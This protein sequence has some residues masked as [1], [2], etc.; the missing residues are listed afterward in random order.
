[1]LAPKKKGARSSFSKIVDGAQGLGIGVA[2]AA[3]LAASSVFFLA[4]REVY[5]PLIWPMRLGGVVW[6]LGTCFFGWFMW[7][8]R[9]RL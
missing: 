9:D 6:V 7:K 2:C 8:K 1:M 4:K 3:M 5:G